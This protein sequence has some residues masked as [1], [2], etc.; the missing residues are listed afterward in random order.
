ME[1]K[2]DLYL[3]RLVSYMWDG[4][5]KVITGIRRCGKSYLLGTL[6]R[7][8]LLEQGV[9]DNFI[10][11]FELDLAKD[12]RFRNPLE[13]AKAVREQVDGKS[14]QY[15]L[16]VDEI[17][18][19][20]EVP[21]P[22]NP[23]GKAVTFYDALN[24]LKSLPNLDIYVTGS[25]SRML[26][27]DI[28]TEFRGRSDEIRVHPLSF[29]EYYSAVGGDKT[30]AFD[31]YAFYGGMPLILSRPDETA[32]MN[33]LKS[34]FSE[35]YLKDIVER[36]SIKR[37]DI[38]SS[39]LD[40][41]CSSVGS[42]TNP[43]NIANS[44]NSKQKLAGENTVAP[45][46]VKSYIGHLSDAY[47]FEECR[48]F[49]VKGKDYFDYPN[50][51]YCDDL[52]LRNARIDFRQQEMTHIMENIIY[53]ELRIRGCEVDIGIVYSSEKN[54]SGQLAQVAREIDFIA[55]R[56]NKKT[57]IQSSYALETEEKAITETKPFGLTGDSFPKIIVRHDIRK[58]WY[59]DNGI[60]NIGIID[61]L[62]DDSIV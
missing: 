10:L 8:Y 6:F 19:S 36:K 27:S 50:K 33:Y 41:L 18:M 62:L 23:S 40:L 54:K 9:K 7:N 12:I 22:Y 14:E 47:L 59:D 46:T 1:I 42:L 24:D 17:Q 13:L 55:T 16:F 56:G 20:D 49:D 51:Y 52:G 29:S 44:L 15:Y 21:N 43:N 31:N 61:F 3:K 58:R 53:N 2:R 60:L 30:E 32:K 48:R 45:N 38:L 39:T 28:L 37:E 11:S 4:Q 57:Y 26:S 25:N 34:L 5:V 35:V